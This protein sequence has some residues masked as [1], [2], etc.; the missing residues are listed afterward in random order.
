MDSTA[1][2]EYQASTA[3]SRTNS[4]RSDT[5]MYSSYST[6][7]FSTIGSTSSTSS[8]RRMIIP[9]YN[10]QAHNVMQNVIVDAGTDAKVAK[11][12]K[13]GLEVIGL[14]VLEPI[15]VWEGS[16]VDELGRRTSADYGQ[17]LAPPDV[18][19]TPGS[20][21]ASLI[22]SEN[23]HE[24][25]PM[26]PMLSPIP[27][28]PASSSS[29]SRPGSR[30]FFGKLFKKKD[31]TTAAPPPALP[32]PLS[33]PVSALPS[34]ESA[35][36]KRTS[37]L[38]SS[39]NPMSP[40]P[41]P[42]L[43]PPVL[44]IQPSLRSQTVPPRGRP[45]KYIWVVRRW[46]KG[47]PENVFSGM[48]EKFNEAR[49]GFTPAPGSLEGM[50]E[51]R[52][53]WTRGKSARKKGRDGERSREAG[54]HRE[55]SQR[56]QRN[57]IATSSATPSTAS[58][59]H[60]AS[61]HA[62]LPAQGQ[63]ARTLS[64]A[65]HGRRSMES[66]R[67]VSPGPAGSIVSRESVD[68]L[69]RMRSRE[70]EREDDGDESDP[71]DSET[72]WQCTLVVR[73]LHA[74]P[75]AASASARGQPGSPLS[76]MHAP[77]IRA[78][79]AAVVPTPH[80]PKVVALLKVPFPL[81][82]VEVER[83]NLRKRVVTP[84]GIARPAPMPAPESSV[85]NGGGGGGGGAKKLWGAGKEN[86]R[87]DAEPLMLTAEEIKDVVSCTGL[88]LVVREGFGGVGRERR[89]GDGWRLRG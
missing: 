80:H 6:G 2:S 64:P 57:S 28:V 82:D 45:T 14:A 81:P 44:G 55:T 7:S 23:T 41:E 87:E 33:P 62:T 83:V 56:R 65:V 13:R 69:R 4:N 39:N 43:Q 5:S 40:L 16:M 76:Q 1:D 77:A 88:W 60:Q 18:S 10:L 35:R 17:G 71:E 24:H 73:R 47:E 9:L 86:A 26:S 58:L 48:R 42:T 74:P 25:P 67:S 12:M 49:S 78:K 38:S 20:S 15:E 52:F 51:V 3:L 34:T 37:L 63:K 66:A 11:F 29:G 46:L 27:S 72:P 50:V 8:G 70:L 85:Q 19:H 61:Q 79:V 75:P 68:G 21:A 30:K 59:Q 89:K 22:T 36:S 32:L 53:E 31:G 84:Q 54:V